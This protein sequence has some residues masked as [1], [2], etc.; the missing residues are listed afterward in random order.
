[1]LTLIR[2]NAV[3]VLFGQLMRRLSVSPP[4]SPF[5]PEVV[6]AASPA[7]ARWLSLQTARALGVTANVDYPLAASF[8]WRLAAQLLDDLP[9]QDPLAI[10]PMA[11]KLFGLLPGLL[12]EPELGSR[13]APLAQYLADDAEGLK[14]WQLAGRIADVLDRY[15]LYRP[16]QIRAWEAGA[17]DHWQALLWRRLTRGLNDLHR[18]AAI[19]RLLTVLGTTAA[20]QAL[21]ERLSLFAL[22]S[23]PPLFVQV[24]HALAVHV[25]VDLYLHAPT[26][27]FWSDLISQKALARRRLQCPDDADLWEVGHSLLASWGRQGQALQDLLLEH[28]HPL[29]ELD[30]YVEPAVET[31]LGRLQHDIFAL[32]PL[33]APGERTRIAVD[34]SL[35]VHLCHSPA[36][37]CQ[38]LRDQLLAM[39]EADPDLQPEQI[40]VMVPEISRYAPYIEAVFDRDR[41]RD[42]LLGAPFIPWNLSD[43]SVADEHPLVVVFLQL[44]ALPDSRFSQSEVLSYLDVPELAAHFGLDAA[45][46]A[47]IRLWLAQANLRWG[48]GAEHKQ[49]LGLPGVQENTWAQAEQRLFGGYALGETDLFEGIAPIG[50]VEGTGAEALGKFWRLFSKLSETAERLSTPRS[51]A[52]W[53]R[54]ISGLLADFF[55]ERDDDDGRLQKIRD[56]LSEL[57]TQAGGLDEPLHP[58]LLR[59]W[60]QQRLGAETRHGR[61]FSGGVTFCGMRPL[62]SLPFKVI[63]VLGLQDQAFPRRDRPAEFD[64]MRSSWRP[65]DPRKADE[66]RYLFL[67]TL[68][69]ARQRLYLSYV[70]R[71]IRR[72][73]ERQPSVLLRELLD[74]I[75]QYYLPAAGPFSG[76]PSGPDDA[77]DADD[78]E[79]LSARL[80]RVHPLQ[81]F[82]ARHYVGAERSYDRDWCGVARAMRETPMPPDRLPPDRSPSGWSDAALPPAP[83]QMRDVTLA[84]LERFLAHPIRYFVNSRLQLYLREQEPEPDEEPFGLDALQRFGLRQQLVEG[85]LQGREPDER[86]LSAEGRLPHGAFAG[87][88]VQQQRAEVSPLIQQLAPYSGLQPEQIAVDLTFATDPDSGPC[89]LSGQLGGIYPGL[90]LLRWKPAAIK[91]ADLLRLWLAHLA[92]CAAGE[93]GEKCS[94]LYGLDERFVIRAQLAPSEARAALSELLGRYWQG[95]HRPLLL[96]PRASFA[97]AESCHRGGRGDPMNAARTGWTGN[98]FNDIPGDQDD[99]YVQLVMRGVEGNPLE[100]ADF[101]RLAMDFYGPILGSGGSA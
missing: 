101:V 45:S 78:T 93:P 72:N 98:S 76:Q 22:S 81:P 42:R 73:S 21:P 56:A 15:Q 82:S 66:D 11:W 57:A 20:R 95:I 74:T 16:Q 46:V 26:D 69:C 67:E 27:A 48:L 47:Q 99:A 83:E 49:R 36:R 100:H 41:E 44:L 80:V 52:D 68:L 33:P 24:I 62:R 2:S 89:S 79:R 77:D 84:Q 6:V 75:D 19:D 94:A 51:A 97:Y 4:A 90:G 29:Q 3:E 28:E 58:A 7:M 96:L 23:L 87:L 65:G 50:G 43:I 71:D 30:A 85:R 1:M 35:Q 9:E 12:A 59:S 40:L 39:L 8:V 53:Q 54:C 60:L 34:D 91:G 32:R 64:L 17:D 14:R 63:C 18:V 92:W 38:V 5:T 61:Y 13:F 86:Q 37:E 88:A 70:G 10:D 31:L 55:G 25:P